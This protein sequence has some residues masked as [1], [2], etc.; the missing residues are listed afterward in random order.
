MLNVLLFENDKNTR[1]FFKM[2]LLE[3]PEVNIV[4]DTASSE[5]ALELAKHNDFNLILL[6]IDLNEHGINGL[7]VAKRIYA[8]NQTAYMI[9]ITAYSRYAADA[10]TLHPYNYII[11]PVVVDEFIDLIKEI[12]YKIAPGNTAIDCYFPVKSEGEISYLPMQ[13]II[14][15]EVQNNKA[16]FH[17]RKG[18]YYANNSL[19]EIGQNL[20]NQFLRVHRSF[21]ANTRQIYKVRQIYDRS[22]DIEFWNY[23]YKARMSRNQ[24]KKYQELISLKN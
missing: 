16:I 7:E 19:E 8:F 14:F 15:I 18:M 12:A 11:K 17:T 24:Y 3:I 20:T 4:L 21:I 2:L 6:D 23:Q 5:E 22:Y 13:D 10:F 9:F 1:E